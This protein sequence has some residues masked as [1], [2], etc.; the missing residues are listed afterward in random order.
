MGTTSSK[1]QMLAPSWND[2]GWKVGPKF[3]EEARAIW[4]LKAA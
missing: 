4:G 3:L 1:I 2:R